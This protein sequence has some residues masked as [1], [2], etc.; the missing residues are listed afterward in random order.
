MEH[1]T[2][3]HIIY[4]VDE[5]LSFYD[6]DW[7]KDFKFLKEADRVLNESGI[8]VMISVAILV[9]VL[10]AKYFGMIGKI[11]PLQKAI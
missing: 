11:V 1:I 6:K 5:I 9:G 10:I 7:D 2:K 8:I 3:T 4:S